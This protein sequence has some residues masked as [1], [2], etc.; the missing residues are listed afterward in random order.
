MRSRTKPQPAP[1]PGVVAKK[2]PKLATPPPPPP[3]VPPPV[4][5]A[6]PPAAVTPPP[7][8]PSAKQLRY[9]RQRQL[10]ASWHERWPERFPANFLLVKPLAVGIHTQLQQACPEVSH[11][12]LRNTLS[13]FLHLARRSYQ[14]A[15]AAGGP[16]FNLDGTVQ[17][18]VTAD[19]QAHARERL[20]QMPRR[21]PKRGKE[22]AEA[23]A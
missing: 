20:A 13:M 22:H 9:E 1:A 12:L 8:G 10:L 15:L 19:E 2:R 6:P 7:A 5:E 16:R 17:A 3:E 14:Q 11:R 18:E 4:T 21:P 23:H